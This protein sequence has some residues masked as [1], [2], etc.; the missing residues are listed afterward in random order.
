MKKFLPILCILALVGCDL[1][2]GPANYSDGNPP[3]PE[4]DEILSGE[5]NIKFIDDNFG[6]TLE[7]IDADE[8]RAAYDAL[9]VILDKNKREN[10]AYS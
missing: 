8:T 4:V 3:E 6:G 2:D 5:E 1:D 10:S 7:M 9:S